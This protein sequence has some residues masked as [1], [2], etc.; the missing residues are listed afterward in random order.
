METYFYCSYSGSRR[1]FCLT[2]LTP[3][4]EVPA[5]LTGG[6]DPLHMAA[7][8]FLT[9]DEY[10]VLW[11]EYTADDKPFFP[12][13]VA[14]LFGV[15]GMHG[16]ISDRNGVANLVIL[17]RGEELDALRATAVGALSDMNAFVRAVFGSLSIGGTCGYCVDAAG[18]GA[19]SASL[20]QKHELPPQLGA[21]AALPGGRA[22]FT[23]RAN[24]RFAVRTV[25]W[26][27]IASRLSPSWLYKK[28]PSSVMDQNTFYAATGVSLY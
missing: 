28:C 6:G 14:G 16:M 19:F 15:R 5:D 8:T 18:W 9:V 24:F 11:R 26:E 7:H 2:G 12:K 25:P 3:S 17:A 21:V 27:T 22:D 13:A 23:A 4:G 10:T 20:L 1:G